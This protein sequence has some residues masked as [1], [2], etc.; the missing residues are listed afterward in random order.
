[1]PLP[2]P[3]VFCFGD[4]DHKPQ[5]CLCQSTLFRFMPDRSQNRKQKT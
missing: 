4:F 1:M 3:I 5:A 2:Y